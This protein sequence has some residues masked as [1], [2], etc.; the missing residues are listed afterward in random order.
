MAWWIM[1]R[2][3]SDRDGKHSG[4]YRLTAKSDEDGGGPFGLCRCPD[5]H[6]TIEDARN[7]S[8]ANETAKHY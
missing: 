8:E 1:V 7:C 6:K 5:G 2:E 3:I 4:R